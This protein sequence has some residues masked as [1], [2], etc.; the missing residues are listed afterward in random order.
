MHHLCAFHG[1]IATG[2][3]SQVNALSDQFLTIANNRF[4]MQQ[5][6]DLGFAAAYGADLQRAKIVQPSLRP[7]CEPQIRPLVGAANTPSDPGIASYM[8]NPFKLGVNEELSV[9]VLQDSGGAQDSIVL[10]GLFGPTP[11]V[12]GGNI[13]TLRGTHSTTVTAN[14]WSDVSITWDEQ[15]K[16]GFYRVVGGTGFSATG[17]AFRLL[18]RNFAYRPGGLLVGDASERTNPMFRNGGIG[19]WLQFDSN[20]MPNVEVL[21][22]GADTSGEIFL[23][24]IPVGG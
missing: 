21:C 16:G 6:W 23:D 9:E 15:L 7:I 22:T 19:E 1:S 8:R 24:I 5:Q 2:V 3:L 13:Y 18:G 11:P 12:A 20:G 4:L 14:A 17:V 10:M